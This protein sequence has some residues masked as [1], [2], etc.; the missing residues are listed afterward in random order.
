MISNYPVEVDFEK[1]TKGN[2]P[3]ALNGLIPI[4]NIFNTSYLI[5]IPVILILA[6]D[7]KP[8]FLSYLKVI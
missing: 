2:G 4:I 1:S 3:I 5:L 6:G 8:I 7:Y